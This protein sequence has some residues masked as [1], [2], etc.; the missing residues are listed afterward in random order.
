M[1]KSLAD[2]LG[3]RGPQY[4]LSLGNV[5]Q[6]IPS[7]TSE[8]VSVRISSPSDPN[9]FPYVIS[10][11]W[12]FDRDFNLPPQILP[13]DTSGQATWSHVRGLNI[14]DIQG[15]HV[16]LLIG[17]NCRVVERIE[18]RIWAPWFN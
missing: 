12:T 17:C 15:S 2:K 6:D 3:L 18:S 5:A 16:G 7:M 14:P 4:N 9:E 13:R 1:S 11:A 8:L 10:G